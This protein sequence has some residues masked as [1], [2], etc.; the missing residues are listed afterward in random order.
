MSRYSSVFAN[1]VFL[2]VG[3]AFVMLALTPTGLN[4][5]KQVLPDFLFCFVFIV[6]LRNP[7]T[8][9][10]IS[11]I[12]ICLLADLL[13]YRPLGLTTITFILA[14]ESLRQYLFLRDKIGFF[15]EFI[16][17]STIYISMTS[18]QEFVKFFTLIPTLALSDII[19]YILSTLLLYFVITLIIRVSGKSSS[20]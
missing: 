20:S 15:E 4:P 1:V 9:T 5:N 13:W 2:F 14:S 19:T 6:L 12:F 3:T 11:I 18:I 16:I 7:K 10:L 8:I 17:I